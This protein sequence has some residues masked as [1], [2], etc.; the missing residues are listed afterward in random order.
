M[1][2]PTRSAGIVDVVCV[3]GIVAPS[4]SD[5]SLLPGWQST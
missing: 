5:W 1:M 4:A 2:S 3:S